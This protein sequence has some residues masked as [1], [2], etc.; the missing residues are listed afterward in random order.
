MRGNKLLNKEH[1]VL[2][3]YNKYHI[4]KRNTNI[5]YIY[6]SL[7]PSFFFFILASSPTTQK[8]KKNPIA[9]F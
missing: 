7:M 1:E 4:L 6:I 8:K 9:T 3:L 5:P 2:F